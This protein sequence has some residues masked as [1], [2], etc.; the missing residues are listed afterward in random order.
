MSKYCSL[1]LLLILG[2]T[3]HGI[4]QKKLCDIYIEEKDLIFESGE[5][6]TYAASYK[7]GPIFTDV[8]E[9]VLS[10]NKYKYDTNQFHV[11]GNGRTYGFYDKFFKVRD[12]YESRF[13]IPQLRSVFFYR[14]IKEGDY[15]MKNY[16]HF[17]W[18]DNEIKAKIRKGLGPERDSILKM[19][20]C[21]LDVLTYFYYLRNLDFSEAYPNKLYTVS[22]ALDHGIYSIKCRYLGKEVKKI[23]ALGKKVHCLKFAVEVIAGSVFKGDENITMWISDDRNHIPMELESPIIVGKLKGRILKYENVKFPI[24]FAN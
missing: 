24:N 17:N 19:N 8:G 14:D 1:F 13:S 2:L 9:V 5:K 16:F 15:E 7:W 12:T 23:K 10:V 22:I 11:I 6:L 3:Q 4:S 21:T 18:T 20:T